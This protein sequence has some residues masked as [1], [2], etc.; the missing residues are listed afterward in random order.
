MNRDKLRNTLDGGIVEWRK[1]ALERMLQRNIT[2]NEVKEAL[3][4]GEVIEIYKDDKP[5]ESALFLHINIKPLHVVASLDEEQSIV[6]IIT[7]YRPD[8]ENFENDFKTRRKDA[9]E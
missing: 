5:F 9:N 6:Y 2:R 1:H 8:N 3:S 7:A 4:F